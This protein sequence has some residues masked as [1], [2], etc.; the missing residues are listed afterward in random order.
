MRKNC[1]IESKFSVPDSWNS[2]CT[3]HQCIVLAPWLTEICGICLSVNCDTKHGR[4]SESEYLESTVTASTTHALISTL[5]RLKKIWDKTVYGEIWH[6]GLSM[7][8]LSGRLLFLHF[9]IFP[10]Q[11]A[12][13]PSLS[14]S[15]W[16]FVTSIPSFCYLK[17]SEKH[18]LSI[19]YPEMKNCIFLKSNFFPWDCYK[20][21][22]LWNKKCLSTDWVLHISEKKSLLFNSWYNYFFSHKTRRKSPQCY[23]HII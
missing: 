9:W 19:Y 13:L 4:E 23:S 21:R 8:S 10:C 6:V 3:I 16:N 12:F 7:W 17:V 14:A 1:Q 11:V 18:Y 22:K 15:L 20:K 2:F 5:F